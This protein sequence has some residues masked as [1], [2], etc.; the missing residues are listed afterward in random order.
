MTRLAKRAFMGSDV[1]M[2]KTTSEK[3]SILN[4]CVLQ[5]Y[6]YCVLFNKYLKYYERQISWNFFI[7]Y[8]HLICHLILTK[9]NCITLT[10]RSRADFKSKSQNIWQQIILS[11]RTV[12]QMICAWPNIWTFSGRLSLMPNVQ[13]MNKN[14]NIFRVYHIRIIAKKNWFTR[15]ETDSPQ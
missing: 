3:N 15:H 13:L 14:K 5:S 2:Q 12:M 10:I 6:F 4:R 1:I 8:F 7:K 9:I 11:S